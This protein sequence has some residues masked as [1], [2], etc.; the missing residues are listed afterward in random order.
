VD[1]VEVRERVR[2]VGAGL[3]VDATQS[4]GAHP[5]D[6]AQ[7]QPDF[8]VAAAYKWLLG[9]YSL[10]FLYVSPQLRTG[11]PLEFNWITRAASEDFASLV[12]YQDDYQPGARRFDAGERSSFA[13]MPMAV[14]ALRLLLEWRVENIRDTL[15]QLTGRIE[16]EVRLLG[17][18]PLPAERRADHL[19]GIRSPL[20]LPPDLPA[21]L[22]AA[23]VYVSVRGQSIRVAPHV[24]NTE[25]DIRRFVDA[26]AEALVIPTP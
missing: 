14:A 15:S 20:P 7:V 13:L 11:R 9:P 21:R 22:A 5:L 19:L 1:L 6:V 8:L 12:D 2:A 26:L 10:G 23:N 17:L 25:D 16:R 4:A 3:V 24:Y 18:E